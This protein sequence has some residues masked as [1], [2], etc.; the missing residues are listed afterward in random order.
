VQT[1]L[2]GGVANVAPLM[3]DDDLWQEALATFTNDELD[4]WSEK[5][6]DDQITL[7]T[8]RMD[9]D[10]DSAFVSTIWRIVEGRGIDDSGIVTGATNADGV[11]SIGADTGNVVGGGYKDNNFQYIIEALARSGIDV[12]TLCGPKPNPAARDVAGKEATRVWRASI[13]SQAL[14]MLDVLPS[15]DAAIVTA[16]AAKFRKQSTDMETQVDKKGVN[17]G[18]FWGQLSCRYLSLDLPLITTDRDRITA[19][20]RCHCWLWFEPQHD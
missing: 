14:T 5:L 13:V 6:T 8:R 3:A 17:L 1:T 18:S 16:N 15:K 20:L 19:A 12:N 4:Q 11:A 9:S 7:I 10:T 2:D